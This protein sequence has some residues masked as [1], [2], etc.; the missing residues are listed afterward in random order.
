MASFD[1][2][3]PASFRGV[4]FGVF[5]DSAEIGRRTV[6]HEFI[7]QDD[8]YVED[9]G[10]L[11]NKFTI[12]G[13]IVGPD[14][15]ARRDALIKALSEKD[16]G[17]LVHPWF[18][19]I[20]V[21]LAGPV[22]VDHDHMAGGYVAFSI[23]FVKC[24]PPSAPSASPS[25][26]LLGLERAGLAG[27]AACQSLH[28]VLQVAGQAAHVVQEAVQTAKEAYER[29]RRVLSGDLGEI[30]SLAGALT[31]VD[32][33][34]LFS[35]GRDIAAGLWSAFQNAGSKERTGFAPGSPAVASG[36]SLAALSLP[37]VTV[38]ETALGTR[39]T[40]AENSRALMAFSRQICVIE[41]ATALATA[42]PESRRQ[43]A[44]LRADFLAAVDLTL[45]EQCLPDSVAVA[46]TDMRA[47]AVAALAEHAGTAPRVVTVA[48]TQ[49]MP[50]LVLAY[51]HTAGIA[52]E[53]DLVARN[54]VIHPGFVPPENLEILQYARN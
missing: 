24:K 25:K 4:S 46:V 17:T 36:Y 20:T 52:L 27:L 5:T 38:P 11:A 44:E 23:P 8:P 34:P 16:P 10:G 3:Q 19:E 13:Y 14:Y 12:Q 41:A 1:Q 26:P 42:M 28:D 22:K 7:D 6:I 37:A 45:H 54:R 29:V 21:A 40:I 35:V 30:V 39:R 49:T 50:A 9:L 47:A 48:G 32:I 18:G 53:A 33:A 15:A 51:R 43:A 31:G 2:L